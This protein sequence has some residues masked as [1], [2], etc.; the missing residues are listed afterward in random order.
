MNCI[1]EMSELGKRKDAFVLGGLL[2]FFHRSQVDPACGL[3]GDK[4]LSWSPSLLLLEKTHHVAT[5]RDLLRQAYR[6][7]EGGKGNLSNSK[8]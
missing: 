6:G 1:A 4:L 8:L 5:R 7:R 2:P 3:C